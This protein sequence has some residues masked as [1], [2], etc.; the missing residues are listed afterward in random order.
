MGY[1][2]QYNNNGNY[3]KKSYN[4]NSGSNGGTVEMLSSKKDGTILKVILNNQ[5]LVLKGLHQ[6]NLHKILKYKN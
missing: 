2:P 4:N 1:K 3:Q 6:M 5:N